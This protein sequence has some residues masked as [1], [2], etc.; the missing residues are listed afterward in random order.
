MANDPVTLSHPIWFA[1]FGT[2]QINGVIDEAAWQNA[3]A[4]VKANPSKPNSSV[5]IRMMY[6]TQALFIAADIRDEQLWADG[7]GGGRGT[8]WDWWADD[9]LALYFDPSNRRQQILPAEGRVLG[10]NMGRRFGAQTGNGVVSRFNYFAG[11]GTLDGTHITPFGNPSQGLRWGTRIWGTPNNNSDLDQGWTTEIRIPWNALGMSG[12]PMNGQAIT[13]NFVAKFDDDGGVRDSSGGQFD[14]DPSKRFG[15]RTPDDEILGVDSSINTSMPG[16][17]GPIN[18]AQ[19]VFVNPNQADIPS[20]ITNLSVSN[21]SGY[22][23]RLNFNA[24]FGATGTALLR[25]NARGGVAGYQIRVSDSPIVDESSWLDAAPIDNNFVP[26]PPNRPESLRIGT[27]Q[28]GTQ[29]YVA[30]RATDTFGRLGAIASTSFTTLG[31]TQDD[32]AGQR[33]IPSPGGG[34]LMYESGESFVMVGNYAVMNTPYLRNLYPGN[35]WVPN[36]QVMRN[37]NTS[38]GIEGGAAGY[39][40]SL[41]A[42]GVNTQRVLLEWLNLDPSGRGNLP[43]GMYWLEYPAGNFNP[44]MKQYLW[45]MMEQADRV[46][47]KLI[48]HP[49]NTFNYKSFF[50]LSA[51]STQNGG[52][53]NTINDFFQS[54]QVLTMAI[55]RVKTIMDWVNESPHSASVA[56]IELINEFDDWNWTLNARGNGDPTRNLEMRDRARFITRLASG[57]R[58]HDADFNIVSS[59]IGQVP[60]GPLARAMFISDAFDILAPHYYTASTSEPIH[61]PNADK[62][63]APVSDYA[64][65]AGYWMTAR[66]DN[67]IVH[68]GE[69][70]N[71]PWLWPGG[72][73]YYTGV[74]PN[75]V[76]NRPW[77]VQ[78]DVDLYRTTSWTQLAMGMGGTGL[79]LASHEMRDL[80]PPLLTQGV[81]GFLPLPLPTGMREIQA[82]VIS[83]V[84]DNFGSGFD[85]NMHDSTTLAGRLRVNAAGKSM[86]AVGSATRDQG[87]VYIIQDSN[88]STGTV[89]SASLSI[90]GQTNGRLFNVEIWS[91]GSNASV[92]SVVTGLEVTGGRLNIPLPDF[93]RDVMLKYR[94]A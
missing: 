79:R 13:M 67:R 33:V 31:T 49:F 18:Y 50:E 21:V 7:I 82:S 66:R 91:T 41:T 65:L 32:S 5:T 85:W 14:P 12:M 90:D 29:Y 10:L 58:A 52:P 74:S 83:F 20:Q 34:S 57:A 37:F 92:M 25:L 71:V 60:R 47:I 4:I 36:Q 43:N 30:V 28:S 6:N 19:L 24:P 45:N 68:N 11:N 40:D 48:L 44:A 56:G 26:K 46:G 61:N 9:S 84:S 93:G 77:T 63:I 59:S 72:R 69:W 38:P 75:A 3:P 76:A 62:S 27:L 89:S 73:T 51:W 42:Y 2:P 16:M 88:R 81:H 53:L 35:I 86:I 55:N 54:P 22:G 17:Q 15:P 87:L 23:A 78:N 80:I 1:T 8:Q 64:S 70:G 39:F 94:T